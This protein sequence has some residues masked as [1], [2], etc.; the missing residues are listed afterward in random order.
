MAVKKTEKPVAPES[1]SRN[2]TLPSTDRDAL[3]AKLE[4]AEQLFLGT[5]PAAAKP[6]IGEVREAL[7]KL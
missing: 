7:K 1:K 4:Q 5:F 3:V 6:I 2:L